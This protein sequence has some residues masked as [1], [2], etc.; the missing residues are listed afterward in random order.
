[1]ALVVGRTQVHR[2]LRTSYLILLPSPQNLRITDLN[3][4]SAELQQAFKYK[5]KAP[6][7][8]NRSTISM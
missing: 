4:M 2:S 5:S 6:T 3:V 7:S 8:W 1:M